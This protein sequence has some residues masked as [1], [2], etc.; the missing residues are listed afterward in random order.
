MLCIV[1]HTVPRVGRSYEQ[2]SDGFELHPLNQPRI[3]NSK[4]TR[5]STTLSSEDSFPHAINFWAMRGASL[6]TLPSKFGGKN[7]LVRHRVESSSQHSRPNPQPSHPKPQTPNP[8]PQIP[9]PNLQSPTPNPP[10]AGFVG[11]GVRIHPEIA[12][13]SGRHGVQ[14][15]A[16]CVA[17]AVLTLCV[18][19]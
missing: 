5:W 11:G 10:A 1:P 4:P 14:Y 19:Q 8:T 9:N 13:M 6:V 18:W 12:H 7:T 16:Q 2:L 15:C 3:L 17:C